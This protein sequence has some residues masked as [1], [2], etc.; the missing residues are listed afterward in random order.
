[1]HKN[2]KLTKEVLS[3]TPERKNLC[4]YDVCGEDHKKCYWKLALLQ[5]QSERVIS[6]SFFEKRFG[7]CFKYDFQQPLIQLPPHKSRFP[8]S[9]FLLTL[10]KADGRTYYS[11]SVILG[12]MHKNNFCATHKNKDFIFWMTIFITSKVHKLCTC[13]KKVSKTLTLHFSVFISEFINLVF[14]Y[15]I[16]YKT[17][18]ISVTNNSI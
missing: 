12:Q 10:L 1:M 3:L 7:F 4:T 17:Y 6:K 2:T 14:L 5:I 16:K 8:L 18:R 11:I 13:Y 15:I 9:Q